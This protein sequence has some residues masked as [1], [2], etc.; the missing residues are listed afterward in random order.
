[1]THKTIAEIARE[2]AET[3]DLSDTPNPETGAHEPIIEDYGQLANFIQDGIEKYLAQRAPEPPRGMAVF[4]GDFEL[5]VDE[6]SLARA[7]ERLTELASEQRYATALS[8]Q[9]LP[10]EKIV[11]FTV[12]PPSIGVAEEVASL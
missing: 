11:G 9:M 5:F 1:M 12:R 4:I 7:E 6:D 10:G 3:A 8:V 2:V